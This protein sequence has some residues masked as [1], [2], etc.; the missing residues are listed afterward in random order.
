MM[1][2]LSLA[3]LLLAASAAPAAAQ[4]PWELKVDLAVPLPVELP[5]VPALNPFASAVSTPPIQ[6]ATPL[7]EKAPVRLPV[8]ASVYIDASG[9]CRRAVFTGLP[10]PGLAP[11][12]VET[13]TD[14]SFNPGRSAGSAV[15]TWVTVGL[16]LAG[17]I[18]EGRVVRVVTARPDPAVPPIPESEPRPVPEAT[19]L[20]LA[21]VPAAQ[22]DEAPSP[23]RF[24]VRVPGRTWRQSV[25]LLAEV[26]P[27]G[28][29][30]R[31]VFLS[32]PEGLRPWLLRSLASWTFQPAGGAEGP[33][34]AWTR[35]DAEL[36][37][38]M[39]SL[40]AEAL[41]VSRTSAYPLGAPAAA[42]APPPGA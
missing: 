39:S 41:R 1:R 23:R 34:A 37:V 38:K 3:V 2:R 4:R 32:C 12:L 24:H 30:S 8:S 40:R 25:R 35:V 29:C 5:A 31:V 7:D 28:R 33:V 21:A 11:E 22:L 19:D 26:T 16:D 15:P 20:Q 6:A 10:L 27:A 13:L 17:R 9:K 36:E 18:D 42:A 14:T